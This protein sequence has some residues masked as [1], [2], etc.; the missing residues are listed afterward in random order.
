MWKPPPVV[1]DSYSSDCE[2]FF[3]GCFFPLRPLKEAI[4]RPS[5]EK[6]VLANYRPVCNLL[7]LEEI[8]EQIEAEQ[9]WVYVNYIFITLF[10]QALCLASGQ[11]Q[12]YYFHIQ[13]DTENA[14]LFLLLDFWN[15]APY[16]TAE[17][18]RREGRSRWSSIK[19]FFS[20]QAILNV[21]GDTKSE[22]WNVQLE[23]LYPQSFP[24]YCSVSEIIPWLNHQQLP[25][26][27][28]DSARTWW[29][30]VWG[31]VGWQG[32][33]IAWGNS[34]WWWWMEL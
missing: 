30:D 19:M 1:K 15:H 28:W 4:I 2:C 25:L 7:F 34:H 33:S 9:L 3:T 11:W 23:V 8:I 21:V 27:C 18:P 22:P 32:V 14:S 26:L 17:A 12:L 6:Q 5:V 31:E 24:H 29:S 10:N 13:M 16:H 20:P